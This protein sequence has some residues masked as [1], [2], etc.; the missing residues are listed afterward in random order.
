MSIQ[1]NVYHSQ[2]NTENNKNEAQMKIVLFCDF[3]QNPIALKHIFF[4]N[5]LKWG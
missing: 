2:S 1:K 4:Y 5:K 3:F